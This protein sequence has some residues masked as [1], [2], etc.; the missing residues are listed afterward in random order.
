MKQ[1]ELLLYLEGFLTPAR[2]LRFQEVLAQ[3]TNFITVAIEDVFQLH[4]TSA[5]IRSCDA[6]GV[7]EVHVVEDR[8]GKRMDKN[9]AM[10]AEQWVDIHRYN[11]TQ[12]CMKTLREK[13]FQIIATSPHGESTDLMDFKI[14]EPIALFFGTE[15]DGLSAEVLQNADGFLRIPMSGFSES[16]NISVAAAICLC[17]LTALVRT[18]GFAWNLTEKEIFEKR[19]DWTKKSIKNVEAIIGRYQSR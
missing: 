16:L 8:F 18:S 12:S 17:H 1:Q 3:R 10:G 4:N 11:N 14:S 6:F 5:V 2:I 13:G 9:I 19:L 15:K 7:Q